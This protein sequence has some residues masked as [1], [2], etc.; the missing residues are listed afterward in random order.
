MQAKRERLAC[1][2]LELAKDGERDVQTLK[3]A[4]LEMFN[5]REQSE[6][7]PPKRG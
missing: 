3:T 7:F 1:V 4:A 5:R 6:L 2:V